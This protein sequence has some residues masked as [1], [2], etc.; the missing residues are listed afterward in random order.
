MPGTRPLVIPESIAKS[1]AGQIINNPDH[2]IHRSYCG[3]ECQPMLKG[4]A[5]IGGGPCC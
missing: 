5:N 1:I 2:K 3:L 4:S